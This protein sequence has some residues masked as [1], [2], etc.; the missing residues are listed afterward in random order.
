MKVT[1]GFHM[2]KRVYETYSE[3]YK[4]FEYPP[5][6]LQNC[7]PT[8]QANY[9][10]QAACAPLASGR[11]DNKQQVIRSR[12]LRDTWFVTRFE[13]LRYGLVCRYFRLQSLYGCIK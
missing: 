7:L 4:C 1:V 9:Q 10:L 3:L 12:G 8:S 6:P 5:P 13:H 2:A 11:C